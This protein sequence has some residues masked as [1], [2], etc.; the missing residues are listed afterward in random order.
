[1]ASLSAAAA[2]EA[3][4]PDSAASRLWFAFYHAVSARLRTQR[5]EPG[6]VPKTP[7]QVRATE[8]VQD[9]FAHST[10]RL[11]AYRLRGV[12]TDRELA[13]KIHALRVTADYGP[14]SVE[15]AILRA[16]LRELRTLLEGL[17]S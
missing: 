15:P 12:S 14:T 4:H 9:R 1:M 11:N 3:T 5:L 7:A 17:T 10:V 13:D 16:R 8:R 2:I 6:G